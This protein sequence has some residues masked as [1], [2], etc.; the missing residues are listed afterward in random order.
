MWIFRFEKWFA[1]L[2]TPGRDYII[3][4]HTLLKVFGFQFCFVEV[5]ISRFAD[6][7]HFHLNRKLNVIK[8]SGHTIA[9]RQGHILY[10][11]GMGEIKLSLRGMEIELSMSPVHASG[12][13]GRELKIKNRGGGYLE[14]K[15][16]YLKA[17]VAGKIS[18]KGEGE[19]LMDEEILT[20]TGYVDYLNSSMSPFR[21]P[22]RQL[23]W[24][25]LH[26]QD[27]DLTYSYVLGIHENVLG[28]QMMIQ[29]GGETLW[30]DEIT[31]RAD[32]REDIEPPG[33]SCPVCYVVEGSSQGLQL[34][35][36]VAH[37]KTAIISEFMEN[38]K[39]L[40]RHG[41]SV[42]RRISKEPKGIK[43][44]SSA[45][46]EFTRDGQTQKLDEVLIIDEY[47]RFM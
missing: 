43:F 10:E 13:R 30:L 12:F 22:V 40:G 29:T 3:V 24:G 46:L 2:L 41:L 6:G 33:I 9:T 42:L 35:L 15:P 1:D 38:P 8:R 5:N 37:L 34:V 32:R 16:I 4:F 45:S 28:A 7:S 36:K 39:E 11:T 47:V 14:W 18:I 20:G 31:I 21:I 23:Y 17:M 25:R 27:L 44:Y 19:Q 26:S